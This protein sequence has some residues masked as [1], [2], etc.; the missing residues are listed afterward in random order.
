M[1]INEWT[2]VGSFSCHKH[3][4]YRQEGRVLGPPSAS[5]G[6]PWGIKKYNLTLITVNLIPEKLSTFLFISVNTCQ[7]L[8]YM[9]ATETMV[10]DAPGLCLGAP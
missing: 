7:A 8:N 4:I 5:F 9:Q 2:T 1:I 6:K 3:A 10:S